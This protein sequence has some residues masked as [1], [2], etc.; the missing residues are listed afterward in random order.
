MC[1]RK[2]MK[3]N[4]AFYALK[5]GRDSDQAYKI[6]FINTVQVFE[7]CGDSLVEDPMTRTIVCNHLGFWSNATTAT[8][9]AEIT[10]KVREYTFGT[11]M[12][13]VSD[14]VRYS[15]MIRGLK[16][17]SLA[18]RDESP[19]TVTEA[20]N[21]LSKWKGDDSSAWVARYYEGVSFTNDTREPQPDLRE[22]QAWNTKTTCRKCQKVG[23]IVTFFENEKVSNTNVQDGETRVTNEDAVLKLMVAYQ[24][25]ANEDFYAYLFLIEEQEHRSTSFHTKD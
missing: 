12:I 8:E 24:E 3:K 9:V 11:S 6:K 14:P 15:S 1:L 20:Y 18:G 23:H 5:Q 17:A 13:S 25:G 10:K 16:N 4:A 7:Q 19:K 21:Y 22:P 2:C